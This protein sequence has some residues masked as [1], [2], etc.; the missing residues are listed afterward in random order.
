MAAKTKSWADKM[1]KP[2][3]PEVKKLE[4]GFADLQ[5]NSQMLI[6]TPQLIA[7]YLLQTTPGMAVD[8]KQMRKDLAA[9]HGADGTCPLTT[10]IFLRIVTEYANEQQQNPTAAGAPIP[11]WRAVHPALSFWKKLTFNTEWLL[12]QRRAEGILTEQKTRKPRKLKTN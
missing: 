7:Q 8:I 2:A 1:Q 4:H 10:G 5:E 3:V 6:P 11:V 9:K 12:A